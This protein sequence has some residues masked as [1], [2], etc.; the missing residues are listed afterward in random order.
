MRAPAKRGRTVS[1]GRRI[2]ASNFNLHSN[3]SAIRAPRSS[4]LSNS[5]ERVHR[6]GAAAPAKRGRIASNGRKNIESSFN[7]LS[8]PAIRVPAV[9]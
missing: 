9:I 5:P 1:K 3:I 7:L 2:I 8:T 6:G 4:I